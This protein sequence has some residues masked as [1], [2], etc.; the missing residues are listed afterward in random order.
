VRFD[1]SV[2]VMFVCV[3]VI[4]YVDT[5]LIFSFFDFFELFF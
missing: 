5:C 2:C 3:R 1:V 4:F